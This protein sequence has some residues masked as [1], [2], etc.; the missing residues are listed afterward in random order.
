MGMKRRYRYGAL[1][2]WIDEHLAAQ[3]RGEG[4]PI[5]LFARKLQPMLVAAGI[6]AAMSSIEI[7][8]RKNEARARRKERFRRS[9][10]LRERGASMNGAPFEQKLRNAIDA[11]AEVERGYL[12]MRADL[13]RIHERL[14]KF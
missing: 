11:L 1:K 10:A 5:G 6:P 7:A 2:E 13:A 3:P 8:V 9:M 4:E 14:G 12:E